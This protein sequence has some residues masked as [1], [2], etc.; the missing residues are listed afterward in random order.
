LKQVLCQIAEQGPNSNFFGKIIIQL[1]QAVPSYSDPLTKI[2]FLN[3]CAQTSIAY[4][5]HIFEV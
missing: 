3:N 1:I 5:Y 4:K 2:T